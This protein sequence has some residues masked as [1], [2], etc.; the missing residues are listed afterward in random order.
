M[1]KKILTLLLGLTC[2]YGIAQ[3]PQKVTRL[4]ISVSEMFAHREYILTDSTIRV[5]LHGLD[6]RDTL[7]TRAITPAERSALFA[8]LDQV[9]LSTLK[10]HYQNVGTDSHRPGYTFT[11]VKG[12]FVKQI[13]LDKYRLNCLSSVSEKLDRL[14]P[15]AFRLRYDTEVTK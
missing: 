5:E 13:R 14:L 9:Y 11:V 3:Q 15:E 6:I 4:R 2:R 10:S 7:F 8:P 12:D 1:D